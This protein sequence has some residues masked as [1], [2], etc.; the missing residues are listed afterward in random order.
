MPKKVGLLDAEMSSQA[1]ETVSERSLLQGVLDAMTAHIALL[2]GEGNIL[3]TNRAWRKFAGENDLTWSEEQ[4]RATNYLRVCERAAR[5]G[6]DDARAVASGISAVAA[7]ERS[8]FCQVYDCSSPTEDRTFQVRVS[9]FET[10]DG[11]R[12][13][14]VHER[15]TEVVNAERGIRMRSEHGAHAMRRQTIGEMASVVSHEL[16]QPLAAI[17]NYAAGCLRLMA[18]KPVADA[19]LVEA[20]GRINDEATRAGTL[21]ARIREF[22]RSGRLTLRRVDG[23]ELVS[24]VPK[25]AEL[26]LRALGTRLEVRVP[27][28]P[29][30]VQADAVQLQQ[31]LLNLVRNG[32]QAMAGVGDAER[33]VIVTLEAKPSTGE[34]IFTVDDQ[35]P[36]ISDETLGS[37]FEPFFTTKS[38]G[39]GL[40]LSICQSITEAHGGRLSAS[41]RSPEGG[42]RVRLVVPLSSM[43]AEAGEQAGPARGSAAVFSFKG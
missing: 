8:E 29:V 39:L 23:R 13:L 35:G 25:L 5:G 34:A 37:L 3:R 6:S 36:P 17:T 30:P 38:D 9:R 11:P 4:E 19:R 33:V 21:L 1:C 31:V 10:A 40:G 32:A 27:E 7:G 24:G 15:V 26:Q 16:N 28:S 42:L 14:V 2:D 18:A 20:M 22:I 12:V 43:A 41:R